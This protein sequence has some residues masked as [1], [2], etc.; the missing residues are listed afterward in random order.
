MIELG[1]EV[2]DKISGFTGVAVARCA[3]LYGCVRVSV[4]PKTLKDGVPIDV[5][6]FDEDQL[7]AVPDVARVE[8][9]LG[10]VTGG[11]QAMPGLNRS[12]TR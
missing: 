8:G 11:D 7:E 12:P 10:K 1:Q 6:T 9:K 2:R 5:Q 4:F 3:W